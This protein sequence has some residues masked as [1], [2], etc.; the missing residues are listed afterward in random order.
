MRDG[1]L[2]T[3][4]EEL[5]ERLVADAKPVRPLRPPL[6][7]T[8]IWLAWA[9]PWI[10][11]VVW[12]MGV[13]PDIRVRAVDARWLIE[14]GAAMMTA[15]AAAAA[16][17]CA[18]IPGRPRW[19]RCLPLLPLAIWLGALG[20][21]CA[22]DWLQFGGAGLAVHAD[23]VCLPGVVLVG[24]GPAV[25]I[26]T[27][28]MRGSP[29]AP[30]MTAMLGALAAG[31][32]AGAALPLIHRQDASVMVLVWQLGTV[33]GLTA[34]AGLAGRRVLSWRPVFAGRARRR[35]SGG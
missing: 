15:V 26:A 5:I 31:G 6:V 17:F 13:R 34:L 16:A 20:Q 33:L 11:A 24:A 19:E 29:V 12:I 4:T 14:E 25:V 30:A 3:S 7:R 27:M 28:I 8:A 32:L 2:Q 22:H 10:A 35:E 23:W 1:S 21:G 18:G 9:A